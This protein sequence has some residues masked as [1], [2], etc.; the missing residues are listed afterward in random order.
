M[1]RT[2]VPGI[3]TARK[4][5][6]MRFVLAFLASFALL[7][8]FPFS[9]TLPGLARAGIMVP[10]QPLHESFSPGDPRPGRQG[11]AVT[12]SWPDRAPPRRPLLLEDSPYSRAGRRI[13]RK[14]FRELREARLTA[15][16]V[17]AEVSGARTLFV[18]AALSV[19][20][21]MVLAETGVREGS[22]PSPPDTEKELRPE[23][24][25]HSRVGLSCHPRCR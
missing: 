23:I 10:A 6:P 24:A 20:G 18:L 9:V 17:F 5:S 15:E 14:S 22:P 19:M 21:I 11:I 7:G 25:V 13:Y 12:A 2:A 8:V 1:I 3:R 16:R 4:G